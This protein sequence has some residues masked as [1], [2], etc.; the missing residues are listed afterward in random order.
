MKIS[1]AIST[2]NRSGLLIRLI[3][4]IAMQD[5]SNYEIVIVDDASTDGTDDVVECF[6]H[7]HPTVDV[8]Y[9]KNSCNMNVS[10]SKKSA[11]R[12]CSGDIIVFSDDDD[13]YVEKSY[14]RS[15]CDLYLEHSDCVMTVAPTVTHY[16]QEDCFTLNLLEINSPLSTREYLNGFMTKYPKPT[17]MFTQSMRASSIERVGYDQLLCLND[18]PIYLFALLAEGNVYAL[19]QV[20]GV[21]SVHSGN[22]T[23]SS[24]AGLVIQNLE[25]KY[26]IYERAC[27]L[28]LLDKPE[29]WIADQLRITAD[30]YLIRN[31]ETSNTDR[32]VWAWMKEH[33]SAFQYCGYVAHV[34]ASRMRGHLPISLE[35]VF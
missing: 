26:D 8:K 12:A 22:M 21:Y 31:V 3:E 28:G 17:S 16:A 19:E 25:A 1:I 15:I 9:Y 29:E 13:Y 18:T 30:H 27:G 6:I 10:A 32:E 2:H 14:F 24:A 33:T 35:S 20:V 5:Y 11:Y 23:G 34:I 7:E 4:S